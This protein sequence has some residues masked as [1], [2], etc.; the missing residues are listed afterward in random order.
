MGRVKIGEL[1]T[2]KVI[3]YSVSMPT[4]TP[5]DASIYFVCLID[6]E[7]AIGLP[8]R[9]EELAKLLIRDGK[10]S[11]AHVTHNP[12][13]SIEPVVEAQLRLTYTTERE[14]DVDE[15]AEFT[16]GL[17]PHGY[18]IRVE[19]VTG[20]VN[21]LAMLF[22]RILTPAATLPADGVA[23]EKETAFEQPATFPWTVQIARG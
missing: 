4:V 20:S 5:I 7:H 2:F 21:D 13:P 22:S 17:S 12:Q 18:L 16:S 9:F 10:I 15:V 1:I 19:G 14:H 6:K 8:A 11:N 23:L 3:S